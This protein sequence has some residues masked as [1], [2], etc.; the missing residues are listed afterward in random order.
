MG[1]E[2][3]KSTGLVT[4]ARR[5]LT[6]LLAV[7]TNRLELLA[8]EAREEAHRWVSV[9]LLAAA[10]AVMGTLA[11]VMISLTIVVACWEEHRL[12]AFVGLSAFY[13]LAALIVAWKLQQ[14]LQHRPSFSATI[15]E[16]KKD[17]KALEEGIHERTSTAQ[18]DTDPGK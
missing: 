13:L 9:F 3:E 7:I 17:R 12:A 15:G 8:V 1:P 16:L 2:A 18:K 14:G 5:L 4:S 6:S 10:L 11:V